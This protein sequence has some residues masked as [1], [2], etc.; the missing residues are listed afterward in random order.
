MMAKRSEP[1]T[2][3][4]AVYDVTLEQWP[5]DEPG[6]PDRCIFNFKSTFIKRVGEK[7][8]PFMEPT[9]FGYR[10]QKPAGVRTMQVIL[11]RNLLLAKTA[12]VP[13]KWLTHGLA[14]LL[15]HSVNLNDM[16]TDQFLVLEHFLGRAMA[17]L[18]RLGPESA[19]EHG[20]KIP[21]TDAL[22]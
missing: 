2:P 19:R 12:G 22:R 8:I 9:H 3:P 10:R 21:L 1:E 7:V 20:I 6:E 5:C 18:G 15:T 14:A 13:M 4:E 16:T 11:G 17:E